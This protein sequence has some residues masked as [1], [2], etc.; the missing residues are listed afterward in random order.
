MS[1]VADHLRVALGQMCSA[2]THAPNIALMQEFARD[3]AAVGADLLC[4]PEV[5][6][7]MCRDRAKALSQVK[8]ASE[9]P[10]LDAACK[11]ARR[12]SIWIQAGTTPVQPEGAEKFRNHA[13][14]IAPDGDVVAAYDKIHLFDIALAGQAPIGESSRFDAGD[15]AVLVDTP[16]GP[17]G[18]SV[19]YDIRFAGLFR[20]YAKAGARMIFV[21]SAFTVATGQ[22]HWEV[23]L[24]ARAIE[25]GSFIVAAAQSGS[26]ED[27]RSTYG[28]S[29]IVAPWGEV[30]IDAGTA[31]PAL[32]LCDLDLRRADHARAQIPNLSHER[33]YQLSRKDAR[34]KAR[35]SDER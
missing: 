12:H 14:L 21:P 23:L 22:A 27:G 3:A 29:M 25:T 15:Q 4:L 18:M 33:R 10:F 16:W 35:H 7:L 1:K 2:T 32:H 13:V 19:C 8:T 5:A 28:H 6:G 11:A 20:D 17:W 30:L 31:A 24:R 9:D 26:H 34:N